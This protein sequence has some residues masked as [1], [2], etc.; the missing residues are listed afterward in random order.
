MLNINSELLT[1]EQR[2]TIIYWKEKVNGALFVNVMLKNL[3]IE[4]DCQHYMAMCEALSNNDN[5]E[6][7]LF[8]IILY[9]Y[10]IDFERRHLLCNNFDEHLAKLSQYFNDV[11]DLASTYPSLSFEQHISHPN[12]PLTGSIDCIDSTNGQFIELKFTNNISP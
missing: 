8:D 11:E 5:P 2:N 4:Y 7:Q 12:L 3:V 9:L 6:K 1:K 10:Q